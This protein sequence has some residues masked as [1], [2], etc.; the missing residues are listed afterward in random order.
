M[1]PMP[2]MPPPPS[3]FLGRSQIMASVVVMREAME[4]AST[5]AVRTTLVGSMMPA[6]IMLTYCG[7]FNTE[8]CMEREKVRARVRAGDRLGQVIWLQDNRRWWI[9]SKLDI[10]TEVYRKRKK[11]R[12][13]LIGLRVVAELLVRLVEELAHHDGA[14]DTGVGRDRLDRDLERVLDDLHADLLVEVLSH[15]VVESPGGVQQR[16]AAARHDALLHGG[17]GRVERVGDAVLL[18]AHLRVG[19]AAHLDHRDAARELGQALLQL[20]LLVLRGGQVD[21]GADLAAA[22]GDVGLCARAVEENGVVLADCD[23]LCRAE[24][25]EVKRLQLEADVLR[26]HLATREHRDVL[27]VGLAVVAEAGCF[28][29]GHLHATAQLVHHQSCERVVICDST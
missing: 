18:L 13:N 7:L 29:G 21:A 24:R 5:S 23:A 10:S 11:R 27:Q 15:Q 8:A 25:G 9:R 19:G 4:A 12:K 6:S 20:L 1:P 3:S 17:A 2:P 16:H 28:D 14:L 22:V 26:H